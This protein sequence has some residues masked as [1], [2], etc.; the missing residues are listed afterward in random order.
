M[1]LRP[2]AARTGK[3]GP[4]DLAWVWPL[5]SAAGLG[6]AFFPPRSAGAW[7]D[8]YQTIRDLE[9]VQGARQKFMRLRL[10]RP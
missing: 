2:S 1:H 9:P 7:E 3:E 5:S 6:L 10:S 4:G 8:L